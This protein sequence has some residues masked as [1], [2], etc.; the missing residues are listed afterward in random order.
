V[1]EAFGGFDLVYNHLNDR[2]GEGAGGFQGDAGEGGGGEEF[3]RT[4]LLQ[5]DPPG[6][7]ETRVLGT[8]QL[9]DAGT[10]NARHR[11]RRIKTAN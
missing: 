8:P 7:A 1:K 10:G 2:Q 6:A 5:D 3:H 11:T 4:A 9:E